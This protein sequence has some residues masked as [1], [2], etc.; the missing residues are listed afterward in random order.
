MMMS[1]DRNAVAAL[2]LS[3]RGGPLLSGSDQFFPCQCVANRALHLVGS[4][5]REFRN[6]LH[7]V[8]LR[9]GSQIVAVDDTGLGHSLDR[10]KREYKLASG[11][12][13]AVP[14][15]LVVSHCLRR[16]ASSGWSFYICPGIA[17][18]HAGA[19]RIADHGR[20]KRTR[21]GTRCIPSQPGAATA[22]CSAKSR[23]DDLIIAQYGSAHTSPTG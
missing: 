23:R 16:N 3:G 8:N 6:L 9:N 13:P 14:A 18:R 7:Q 21:F 10:A 11:P 2:H 4:L 20:I 19:Q 17:P 1:R 5:L 15:G 22:V 12:F